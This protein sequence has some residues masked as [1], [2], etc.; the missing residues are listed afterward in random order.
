MKH[1]RREFLE[2]A[3]LLGVSP[4]AVRLEPFFRLQPA[5]GGRKV[6]RHGVASGDPLADR[7]ILWT[8]ISGAPADA[9]PLARWEIARDQ[10]F[11][12]PRGAHDR[13]GAGFHRQGGCR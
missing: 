9:R 5:A 7:V 10:A 11:R 3:A 4:V 8:R 1:S 13:C 6:F 2:A 12:S